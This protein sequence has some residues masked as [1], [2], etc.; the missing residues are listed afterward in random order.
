MKLTYFADEAGLLEIVSFTLT[1]PE[2]TSPE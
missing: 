1:M 2:F